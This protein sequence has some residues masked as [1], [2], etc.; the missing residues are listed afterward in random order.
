MGDRMSMVQAGVVIAWRTL[1]E[2]AT[3]GLIFVRLVVVPGFTA[4][5][6]LAIA[7]GGSFDS[8]SYGTGLAA[9]CAASGVAAAVSSATLVSFD[10]FEA[11]A[12][13]WALAPR[14]G[15]SLAWI[16]RNGIVLGAGLLTGVSSIVA[17]MALRVVEFPDGNGLLLSVLSLLVSSVSAIGLGVFVGVA[18]SSMR[19]SLLLVNL[20]EFGLPVLAGAA[21][22]ISSFPGVAFWIAAAFPTGWATEAARSIE[23]PSSAAR[24]MAFAIAT[25]I[26]W[27]LIALLLRA[28]SR[29][30]RRDGRST[31]VL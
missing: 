9:A 2:F 19:D 3:W 13:Y 28:V 14:L 5:F 20:T 30:R 7:S 6:Y 16:G 12:E 26:V 24:Y 25:A 17:L 29:G 8:A 4:L 27:L 18:S 11:T 15:S 10:R 1:P 31:T 21:A 23:S 22:S